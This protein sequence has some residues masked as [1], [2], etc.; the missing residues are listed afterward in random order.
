MLLPY[1]ESGGE[2]G[3]SKKKEKKRGDKRL[4]IY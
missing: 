1:L 4:H 2:A 3:E